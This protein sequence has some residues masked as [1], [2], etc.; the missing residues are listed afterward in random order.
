MSVYRR[1][2]SEGHG[3][4]NRFGGN[5]GVDFENRTRMSVVTMVLRRGRRFK[6]SGIEDGDMLNKSMWF[7]V[8]M[9]SRC[10]ECKCF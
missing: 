1:E 10:F 2:E 9:K 6:I 5:H 8:D 4:E 7:D 3:H